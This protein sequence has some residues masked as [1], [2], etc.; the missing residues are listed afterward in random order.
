MRLLL[1]QPILDNREVTFV[2]AQN[3]NMSSTGEVCDGLGKTFLMSLVSNHWAIGG[4][5]VNLNPDYNLSFVP[6]RGD[7]NIA[8]HT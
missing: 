5:R 1:Y 8:D 7:Y 3:S 4:L 2:K 6:A